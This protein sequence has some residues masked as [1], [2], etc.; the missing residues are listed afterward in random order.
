LSATSGEISGFENLPNLSLLAVLQLARNPGIWRWVFKSERIGGALFPP[1]RAGEDQAFLAMLNPRVCEVYMSS[2]IIYTYVQNRYGQLTR[3][4][5]QT[6]EL[7]KSLSYIKASKQGENY[8]FSTLLLI[9]LELK[10]RILRFLK[11]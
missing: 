9:K 2:E 8:L 11:R 5:T 10:C 4:E 1:Y 7:Q 3:L 6:A